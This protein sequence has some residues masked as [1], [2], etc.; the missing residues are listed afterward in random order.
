MRSRSYHCLRIH[1]LIPGVTG[2]APQTPKGRRR[3]RPLHRVSVP[4]CESNVSSSKLLLLQKLR[5]CLK[6][7]TS[8]TSCSSRA[9]RSVC[10][11]AQHRRLGP[12]VPCTRC[13]FG[14]FDQSRS[15]PGSPRRS[16]L[17]RRCSVSPPAKSRFRRR[18][19]LHVSGASDEGA[20]ASNFSTYSTHPRGLHSKQKRDLERRK[21]GR[22][23]VS[24]VDRFR[25]SESDFGSLRACEEGARADA[26]V[27][28]GAMRRSPASPACAE[29]ACHEFPP[30]VEKRQILDDNSFAGSV[31][32]ASKCETGQSEEH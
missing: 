11:R 8:S 16:G 32:A 9:G 14:A 23:L 6:K 5:N 10:D 28:A 1:C 7:K 19:C 31:K 15:R 17:R 4:P 13:G 20:A 2:L 29:Q 25:V 30:V 18:C 26:G 27:V 21:T 3:R 24:C 22:L 12:T